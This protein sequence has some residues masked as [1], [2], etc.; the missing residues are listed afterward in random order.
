MKVLNGENTLARAVFTE[1]APK[2][3]DRPYAKFLRMDELE[4]HLRDLRLIK[5]QKLWQSRDLR[6]AQVMAGQKV[7]QITKARAFMIHEKISTLSTLTENSLAMLKNL[8]GLKPENVTVNKRTQAIEV[9]FAGLS[10]PYS[11]ARIELT[12]LLPVDEIQDL[13]KIEAL[14]KQVLSW[15]RTRVEQVAHELTELKQKE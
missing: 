1:E 3:T 9:H 7:A 15:Q 13:Q 4:T 10:G 8:E 6:L 5:N 2:S 14:A 12:G 11:S